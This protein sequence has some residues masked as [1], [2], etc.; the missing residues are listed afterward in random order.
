M[1]VCKQELFHNPTDLNIISATCRICGAC[2]AEMVPT[3][4][5]GILV[6]HCSFCWS[7]N[8]DST[9]AHLLQVL[10]CCMLRDALLHTFV[11]TSGYL[12]YICLRIRLFYSDL[13]HLLA[14]RFADSWIFSLF[15]TILRKP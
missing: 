4:A 15:Q 11:L 9:V 7:R 8:R 1:N 2:P 12:T 5:P 10:M 6:T 14:Q 13:W 3:P